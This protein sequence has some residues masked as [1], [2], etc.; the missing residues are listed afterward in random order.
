MRPSEE[1]YYTLQ[2]LYAI[3]FCSVK[4]DTKGDLIGTLN[5]F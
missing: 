2:Y 5:I 3:R 1:I 4:K